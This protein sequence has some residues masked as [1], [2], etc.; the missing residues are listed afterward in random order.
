MR[1]GKI[2][3]WW[4]SSF[5]SVPGSP[6]ELHAAV[7]DFPNPAINIYILPGKVRRRIEKIDE[8]PTTNDVAGGRA[9]HRRDR[10]GTERR[11]AGVGTGR[12]KLVDFRIC[13]SELFI[14]VGRRF[15]RC[16]E[17]DAGVRLSAAAIASAKSLNERRPRGDLREQSRG[18]NIH[19]RLNDLCADYEAAL[20]LCV[21]N[22]LQLLRPIL[23]SEL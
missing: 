3:G 12:E 1:L 10:H 19:S 14:G 18:G 20:S 11:R 7:F 6:K 4:A 5:A 23:W 2:G 22:F 8:V 13:R 21:R 17:K 9:I 16:D 15:F